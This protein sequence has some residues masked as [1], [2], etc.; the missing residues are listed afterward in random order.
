MSAAPEELVELLD[1]VCGT[2]DRYLADHDPLPRVRSLIRDPKAPRFDRSIWREMAALGWTGLALPEHLGGSDMGIRGAAVVAKL[3]GRHLVPEPLLSTLALATPVLTAAPTERG[4]E[5]LAGIASGDLVVAVAIPPR[6]ALTRG[7]SPVCARRSGSGFVEL[8]G[9][10]EHVIDLDAADVVVVPGAD[11]GGEAITWHAVPCGAPGLH[12]STGVLIDGRGE[13][14]LD[15]DDVQLPTSATVHGPVPSAA[16]FD[17]V[18]GAGAVLSAAALLGIAERA[19]AITIEYLCHRHQFGVPIGSFQALQ[20]RMAQLHVELVV[21]RSVVEAAILAVD[22]GAA[23]H[24][25]LASAAKSRLGDLAAEVTGTAIQYH[26]GVGMTIEAD[27]G[28]FFLAARVVE[29]IAGDRFLHYDRAGDLL[30]ISSVAPGAGST[31][32]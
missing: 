14:R 19:F 10:M 2:V 30:G 20:H 3:C 12:I 31:R 15:L 18:L 17:A 21:A 22:A 8:A 6:R 29:Q 9:T 25:L 4:E 1:D 27:I 16:A 24:F 7:E 11:V 13:G 23:N 5:I 32:T 28:L 26:G